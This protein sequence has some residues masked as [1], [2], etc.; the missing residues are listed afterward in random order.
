M[1]IIDQALKDRV[2]LVTGGSRGIGRAVCQAL[3]QRGA[4]VIINYRSREDAAR[5]TAE[6]VTKAGGEPVLAGFDVADREAVQESIKQ[7]ATDHGGLHILVNNA[8]IA[9]NGLLLRFKPEDWQRSLDVNLAGA[10]YCAQAAARPLLK[11]KAAGRLINITSVVGETGNGGQSAY[12]ATKAGLIGMTKSLAREFS[13]RGVCVNAV[14][15]GYIE[16]EMTDE[17]LPEA[18]RGPLLESIPL[19]RMGAAS[20]VADTVAFLAGPEAAYITGQV[21]R[22][23]GGMLM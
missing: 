23:N 10:Y 12:A 9:L 22:V 4:K 20:D 13:S 2:A 8:G 6:L 7:L 11:A 17:A 5:E 18:A 15:P 19:A 14:S 16:T 3:A 21:I 1:A